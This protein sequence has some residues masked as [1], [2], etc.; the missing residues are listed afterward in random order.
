MRELGI[1]ASGWGL[2]GG[3]LASA[4]RGL[5]ESLGNSTERS[6][7][8]G[9]PCETDVQSCSTFSIEYSNIQ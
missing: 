5:A 3:Q 8:A 7:Q 1:G 9:V 4:Q 6:R 2:L